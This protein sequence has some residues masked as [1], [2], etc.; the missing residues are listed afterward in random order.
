MSKFQATI[1]TSGNSFG[2]QIVAVY[3]R[4]PKG[5]ELFNYHYSEGDH[6]SIKQII[7]QVAY[8]ARIKVNTITIVH[9]QVSKLALTNEE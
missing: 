8:E 3:L 4:G 7:E 6:R 9:P 1:Q 5:Q 2:D